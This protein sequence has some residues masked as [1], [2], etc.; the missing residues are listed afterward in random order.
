MLVF[1]D[2]SGDAG[3]AGKVGQTPFFIVALVLFED[4]D[5]AEK[6]DRRIDLI[7]AELK[8]PGARNGRS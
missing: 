5:E 8:L 4:H 6:V 3:M 7:R 1:V 2:E